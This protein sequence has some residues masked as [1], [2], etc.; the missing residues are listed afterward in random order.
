M[1][2]AAIIRPLRPS[3]H[4]L[5]IVHGLKAIYGLRGRIG[6]VSYSHY[7]YN[8]F[9]EASIMRLRR[10]VLGAALVIVSLTAAS[11]QTAT[12]FPARRIHFVVP[13]PAGGIVDVA[14]RIITTRLSEMWGQPIVVEAKPGAG[15]SLAWDQVSRAEPDGYTWS[16]VGPALISNPRVQPSVRWS[17]KSFV[18]IGAIAWGPMV[19]VVNANVPANTMAE[20]VDHA[21]KNPG[22]LNWVNPGTGSEHHLNS[23]L[24]LKTTKLQM[25]E[26][27]Y[28]GQPPA[29]L[30]L[31]ADRVQFKI[32]SIS[33][34]A[35]H[36]KTGKM[37]A[38]AIISK[39]RSPLLPDVPTVAEAG[40]PEIDLVA[41]YGFIAP[42]G[43]PQ[44]IVDKV[45]DG[46]N[47]VLKEPKIRAALELQ[48]LE[49]A[50]PTTS[51]E[52]NARMEADTEK[53]AKVISEAGIKLDN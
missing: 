13:Y 39:N 40:Y 19:I 35:D 37:K 47:T 32:A 18:P 50:E 33:L 42:R 49:P 48:A 6:D 5:L 26:V 8:I 22:K 20:F 43:T 52:L 3:L 7:N 4:A 28:R 21:R 10:I 45:I 2:V 38:L 31:L 23:A 15:G 29:I 24:F 25:T 14:T 51:A 27:H 30:D 46:I 16:F 53:Y 34:V 9:E 41:W 12:N 11:A 17:E 36:I 44:P 1:N